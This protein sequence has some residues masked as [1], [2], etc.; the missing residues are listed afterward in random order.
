M[1]RFQPDT[2]REALLRPLAM[3]SP[4]ANVYVEIMAPDFRF[5]F[6]LGLLLLLL[7]FLAQG[8]RIAATGAGGRAT[9][10]LTAALAFAFVP[11]LV[12][13][14][15]GR[16]FIPGLLLAGPVC[17]GLVRLLPATRGFRLA[18]ALLM[19]GLQAF[20]VQQSAP[21]GVWSIAEW[22]QPPYF[23]VTVPADLRS[24]PAT[25]V[26]MSSI[27]YSLV[28]PQ[29]DPRSRW[30]NLH[31]APPIALGWTDSARTQ[32]FLARAASGPIFLFV[33]VV[34][35][36]MTSDRLPNEQVAAVID[37]QLRA[38][39]LAFVQPRS[40]RFLPSRGLAGMAL[41]A[42]ER[43]DPAKSADVGFWACALE[44]A[45]PGGRAQNA[46]ATRYDGV[47][48]K[49]EAQCPRFFAGS[50]GSQVIPGGEVRSYLSAEMKAYVL[51]DGSVFYKY[52]RA[53]NPV[54]I[55]SI[56]EVL[57]GKARVDCG[58]IRGRSGLP[59]EREI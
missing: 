50:T 31:E 42:A 25:I 30:I 51:D 20:A 14:A 17:I 27:S 44:H 36:T 54:R 13:T 43:D 53:L 28:A 21:W 16:Y 4:D 58:N 1:V 49:I 29:F 34:P 35:G 18:A 19:V 7:V 11:W 33:P 23:Q 10:A 3:A 2:W 46:A 12:T 47:F 6:V 32:Q 22:R 56:D 39:E 48:G 38:Y 41:R 8:R 9:L 26:T 45:D 57:G 37:D 52:Y 15:N 40:C 59:W 55:G 5:A 24:S